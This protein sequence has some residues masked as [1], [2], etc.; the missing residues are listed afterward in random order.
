MT[1]KFF[2]TFYSLFSEFLLMSLCSELI[3][4]NF[5]FV[6]RLSF[7]VSDYLVVV[8]CLVPSKS[9]LPLLCFR[10]SH[11]TELASNF[12]W[13]RT[14]LLWNIWL[15][16][17]CLRLLCGTR[18][19]GA[20]PGSFSENLQIHVQALVLLSLRYSQSW[21]VMIRPQFWI[22]SSYVHEHAPISVAMGINFPWLANQ[23]QLNLLNFLC[24][25]GFFSFWWWS[26]TA[27]FAALCIYMPKMPT[28][29]CCRTIF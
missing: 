13:E 12:C 21:N 25:I 19:D 2:C 29:R 18:S 27:E 26:S 1:Q 4:R 5:L 14:L 16:L 24:T 8:H 6:Y 22:L 9:R 10:Y 15:L 28:I 20:P 7:A 11:S 23:W 3:I 17:L